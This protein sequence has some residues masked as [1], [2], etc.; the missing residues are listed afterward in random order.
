ML[1]NAK[2]GKKIHDELIS[3]RKRIR[4]ENEHHCKMKRLEHR[5][6]SDCCLKTNN[7]HYG[8]NSKDE[9]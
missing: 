8:A 6:D 1:K 4:A 9:E 5:I 3:E 2:Q 7:K